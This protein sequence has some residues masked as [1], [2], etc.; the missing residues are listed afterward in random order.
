[1][2]AYH[3]ANIFKK[4]VSYLNI[5]C[6]YTFKYDNCQKEGESGSYFYFLMYILIVRFFTHLMPNESFP[7]ILLSLLY[8]IALKVEG[9]TMEY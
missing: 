8:C 4:P 2:N 7:H 3:C 9:V 1:M 6:F 5:H